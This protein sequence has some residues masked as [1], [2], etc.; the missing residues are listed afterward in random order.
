M[1]ETAKKQILRLFTYGLYAVTARD[2]DDVA[3][4][5]VNWATQV[6]FDPPLIAVST[7]RISSSA[8]ASSCGRRAA[9]RRTWSSKPPK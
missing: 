6:S 1:D 9:A 4:M 5:T 8:G 2:E 3:A 7:A